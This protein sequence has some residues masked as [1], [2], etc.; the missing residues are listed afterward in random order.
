MTDAV[1]VLFFFGRVYGVGWSALF[2]DYNVR[3]LHSMAH[4]V[5][6]VRNDAIALDRSVMRMRVPP[7]MSMK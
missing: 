5:G 1:D 7:D 2:C 6:Q 4:W 3:A